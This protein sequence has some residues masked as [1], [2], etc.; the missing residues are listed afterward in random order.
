ITEDNPY[1]RMLHDSWGEKLRQV[2]DSIESPN[3]GGE[4]TEAPILVAPVRCKPLKKITT[5]RDKLI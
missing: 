1:F 2:F 4:A 3:W 5:P